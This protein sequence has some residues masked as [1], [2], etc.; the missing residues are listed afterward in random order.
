MPEDED[1]LECSLDEADPED[2]AAEAL[3][4]SI[5]AAETADGP[6]PLRPA[7][8]VPA[9]KLLTCLRLAA[10]FRHS[11]ALEP[12]AKPG[13]ITVLRIIDLADIDLV[14]G[15]LR[16]VLPK[17]GW[18]LYYPTSSDYTSSKSAEER[19]QRESFKIVDETEPA[20][21]L[22]P[23]GTELPPHLTLSGITKFTLSPITGDILLAQLAVSGHAPDDM[24]VLRSQLPS[25]AT[26]SRLDTVT[27]CAALRFGTAA[28]IAARLAALSRPQESGPRL[29]V[30]FPDSPAVQTA[31]RLVADLLAWRRGEIGWADYSHSI[32]LYGPPGTGKTWLARAMGNSAGIA[33]V[34]ASFAEWQSAGHLGDML[35]E[36]RKS[37]AAA[38]RLSPAILFIDEIDAVGSRTD[39][40]THG[41]NYR[42]QVINGFL[43]EMNSLA[44]EP[45]VIVVGACNHPDKID[46][47]VIRAGRFDLKVEMSMPDAAALFAVLKQAFPCDADNAEL[48]QLSRQCVGHSLASLDAAIRAGR[49]EARHNKQPFDITLLRRQLQ[50]DEGNEDDGILWRTALHEA[51]HAVATVALSLGTIER[52]AISGQGGVVRHVAAP[53]HGLLSDIENEICR[54]LAGRAAERVFLG[55]VSLGSG[56]PAESDL[57]KATQRAMAI[58]ASWGLGALGPVWLSAP[59]FALLRDESMMR[60]VRSVVEAAETRACGIL[61]AHRLQVLDLA[62]R[63]LVE[64]SLSNQEVADWAATVIGASAPRE[65]DPN[66]PSH[67]HPV[68]LDAD[69]MPVSDPSRSSRAGGCERSDAATEHAHDGEEA[70]QADGF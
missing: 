1:V 4:T 14:A 10:T 42:T 17:Q 8:A 35:R 26:L 22:L 20:L 7:V 13:A 53:T 51:G 37:F 30:G 62:K 48:V 23:S 38:R 66:G 46:P 29:E 43:G 2:A 56:G 63:L 18:R 54:D 65:P 64:R 28:E 39:S 6:S 15:V 68:A 41:Q 25:D 55:S 19:F 40:D 12:L 70:E 21:V 50:L 33:C 60:R 5:A 11:D 57:A 24:R 16:T 59:E 9:R 34:T 45:G 31:R 67:A 47:A 44:S 58:E 36:M 69:A 27:A 52:I 3:S 32:L 61:E 49:S